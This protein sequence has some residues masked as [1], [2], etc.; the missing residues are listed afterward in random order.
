M[1]SRGS[2]N[3]DRAVLP[4]E[5]GGGDPDGHHGACT[6]LLPRAGVELP[7]QEEDH[8]I[9]LNDEGRRGETRDSFKLNMNHMAILSAY[10]DDSATAVILHGLRECGWREKAIKSAPWLVEPNDIIAENLHGK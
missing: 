7:Q 6:P 3:A 9:H 2:E 10:S 1:S 5:P 4:G 8:G